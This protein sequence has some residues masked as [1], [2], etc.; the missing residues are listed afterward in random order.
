MEGNIYAWAENREQI[1]LSVG[2]LI[3]NEAGE[4]LVLYR[5]DLDGKYFLPTRTHRPD[6]SLE[7][8]LSE[9][10]EKVGYE[11]VVESWLG[12]IQSEF[13]I[14]DGSVNKTT[15]WYKAIVAAQVDRDP[16]DRDNSAE[17]KWL[18]RAE[19]VEIFAGQAS[20]SSDVDQ[21]NVLNLLG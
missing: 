14:K 11:F 7:Q 8:T 9:I 2:A 13:L 21:R 17:I 15:L 1:H 19:L 16:E 5:S 3:L 10:T 6:Q 4:I 12:T 18:T 20:I